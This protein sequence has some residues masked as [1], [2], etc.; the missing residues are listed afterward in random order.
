MRNVDSLY[1]IGAGIF[2]EEIQDV[3]ALIGNF[4]IEGFVEGLDKDKCANSINGIPVIWIDDIKKGNN[5]P[6]CFCA[7]GS[8][9]R[10]N[11]VEEIE[12][13]GFHFKTLIHPTAQIFPSVQIENGS[14][15]GAGSIVA[16]RTKIGKHVIINRGCLIGHHVQIGNYVTISPGANIAGRCKI[17][18]GSYIGMGAIIIDGITVGTNSVIGAGSVVTKDVP[19]NVQVIG[20]P[21]RITKHF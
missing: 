19:D 21:A 13:R 14:L 9:K 1:I 12:K 3:V 10:K 2:A 18:D 16:A 8:P 4:R 11:I 6:D 7:I 5:K 15:I 20:V 17:K